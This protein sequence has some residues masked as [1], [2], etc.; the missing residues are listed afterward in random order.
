MKQQAWNKFV[1]ENGPRSGRFLQSWDWGDFQISVGESVR[2]ELLRTGDDVTGVAQWLDRAVP[3]FGMYA[4]CPK[5]PVGAG[6]WDRTHGFFS[7]IEP[8]ALVGD[9]VRS[10]ELN[11]A[12]TLI[13]DLSQTED[14]LLAQMHRKTRYNIRVS[15][16]H[17]VHV[18][19]RAVDF[20][21]VWKLFEQTS[22]RGA[23]KLHKRQYY[24]KML[25]TLRDGACRA[26]LATASHDGEL[27]A[28]NVMIDFG[29]TR[30]YLH[31]A[32]S[33]QGRKYMAPYALHWALMREAKE[34]GMAWY[35]WWGVAPEEA[36]DSHP[37]SGITRFKRGFGGEYVGVLGTLDVVEQPLKYRLYRLARWVRRLK[38]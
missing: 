32:S 7:R 11:P 19:L 26:F 25:E 36:D 4:Y 34:Q 23:F 35:D 3:G 9:A 17:E 31:G 12:H 2:R 38:K 20:D 1:L 22:S 14:E 33:S 10:I 37:W 24:K 6:V 29:D 13:T 8:E 16:K 28:A 21:A 30:T 5:G 15:A 18:Q 27:L